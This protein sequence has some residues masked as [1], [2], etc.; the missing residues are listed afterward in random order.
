MAEFRGRR[1]I[2]LAEVGGKAVGYIAYALSDSELE[3]DSLYVIP[4]FRGQGIGTSMIKRVLETAKSRYSQVKVLA[5]LSE[6]RKL[7]EKLG[8]RLYP[9]LGENCMILHLD[10]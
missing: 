8:F 9:K 4:F 10:A 3:I 5:P 7:Y 1:D 6:S 2:I